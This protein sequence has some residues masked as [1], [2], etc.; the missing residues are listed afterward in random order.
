MKK[1]FEEITIKA[2][3]LKKNDILIVD[4]ERYASE[5]FIIAIDAPQVKVISKGLNRGADEFKFYTEENI[6]IHRKIK[7][8]VIH[9]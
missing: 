8:V 5:V 3:N 9:G 2:K 4:S 1:E 6:L 7:E